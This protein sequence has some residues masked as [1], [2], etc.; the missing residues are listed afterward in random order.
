MGGLPETTSAREF[1]TAVGER[2]QVSDNAEAGHL[3]S[4]LIEGYI[5]CVLKRFNMQNCKPGDAPIVKED[6]LSNKQC[7]KNNVKR[8]SMKNIPYASAIGSLMYAQYFSNPEH[9]HSIAAKTVMRLWLFT[10]TEESDAKELGLAA[11]IMPCYI[12]LR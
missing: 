2:F 7:P 11:L 8:K 5:E 6:K 10:T 3:M 1:F 12:R 9:D 4:E